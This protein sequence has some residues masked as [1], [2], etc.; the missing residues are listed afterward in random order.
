MFAYFHEISI[1]SK[2]IEVLFSISFYYFVEFFF[3]SLDIF[4]LNICTCADGA[5][6][7]YLV[8]L[9]LIL[10]YLDVRCIHVS[11]TLFDI[12]NKIVLFVKV[13]AVRSEN[14]VV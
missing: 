11:H 5:H 4:K 8:S 12:F 2:D 6:V 13:S 1:D 7:S 10:P 3:L 9:F 14:S